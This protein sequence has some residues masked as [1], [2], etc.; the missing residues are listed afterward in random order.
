MYSYSKQNQKLKNSTRKSIKRGGIITASSLSSGL[1][2][3]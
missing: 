3:K 1:Y 2:I